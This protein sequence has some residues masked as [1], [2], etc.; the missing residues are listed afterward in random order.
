M[1]KLYFKFG[2]GK[3]ADLCQTAY[4]YR[5]GGAK[6]VVMNAS[7]NQEISSRVKIDGKKILTLEP[8]APVNE[9]IFGQG[10]AFK[11]SH[12]DAIL[13]D[14]AHLLS[15]NQVEQLFYLCKAFGIT[16]ITYGDRMIDG[17]GTTNGAMR[18]MELADT[19]EPVDGEDSFSYHAPLQFY[20][21]AMNAS[22]TAKLLYKAYDLEKKNY[23]VITIKP[24]IDRSATMISSRI[25]LSRMADIVLKPDDS[26]AYQISLLEDYPRLDKTFILVDEAQFLTTEQIKDL[27]LTNKMFNVPIR[28]YG[29]KSDFLTHHFEGSGRLLAI[30]ELK[31]LRTICHCVERNGAEFNA[32]KYKDGEYITEGSQVAVDDG[33]EIAYDSLCDHC[34]IKDVQGIDI[35]NPQKVLRKLMERGIVKC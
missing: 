14:N 30:A 23:S 17:Y 22:K 25:G 15:Q 18:L 11:S 6:V 12:V 7:S 5:E 10:F 32:R 21:G 28:C 24:S 9:E 3:T 33:K 20:Y 34:Y 13:I 35:D 8:N 19:I 16:V 1:K 26:L 4:N 29:L 27:E 31:K 2:N